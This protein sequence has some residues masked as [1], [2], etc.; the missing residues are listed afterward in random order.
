MRQQE[1]FRMNQINYKVMD[2]QQPI[3]IKEQYPEIAAMAVEDII[4]SESFEEQYKKALTSYRVLNYSYRVLNYNYR[5]LNYYAY[6]S[7]EKQGILQLDNF[8]KEYINCIN[9][10]SKLPFAK[11]VIIFSIG[12]DAYARTIKKM[13]KDYG[14]EKK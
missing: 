14:H 4:N 3:N 1:Q 6:K 8:R 2:T 12:N 10:E 7:L 9:K 5:V 13:M 11:R